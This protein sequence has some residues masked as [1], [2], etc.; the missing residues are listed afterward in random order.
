MIFGDGVGLPSWKEMD[1]YLPQLAGSIG[2]ET[3]RWNSFCQNFEIHEFWCPSDLLCVISGLLA[4]EELWFPHSA[5]LLLLLTDLDY[6]DVC[7]WDLFF[8]SFRHTN[9]MDDTMLSPFFQLWRCGTG[10]PFTLPCLFFGVWLLFCCFVVFSVWFLR[11]G[12]GYLVSVLVLCQFNFCSP[13]SMKMDTSQ[14]VERPGR[15]Q[16]ALDGKKGL[17]CKQFVFFRK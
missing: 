4:W 11:H 9:T 12:E 1:A 10:Q 5:V 15:S 17:F 13:P 14:R 8:Y 7:V 6:C 16:E 2:W 3:I